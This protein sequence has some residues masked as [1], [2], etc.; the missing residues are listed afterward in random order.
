MLCKHVQA[1]VLAQADNCHRQT[2][3]RHTM[4]EQPGSEVHS[5]GCSPLVIYIH[6]VHYNK[7][8]VSIDLS[9]SEVP[10]PGLVD[11]SRTPYY[12]LTN[13]ISEC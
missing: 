5:P 4:V 13:S 3:S 7:Y 6:Y 9:S 10:A 1:D 2:R 11:V 12:T 8:Q